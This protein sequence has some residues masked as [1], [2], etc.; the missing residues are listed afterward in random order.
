M[1]RVTRGRVIKAAGAPAIPADPAPPSRAVQRIAREELDAREAAARILADAK[2]AAAAL[3]DEA[4]AKASNVAETAAREAADA[5]QAK[6]AAQYLALR[7]REERSAAAQLDRSVEL[8]RVLAERLVGESL[9]VDEQTVAK[10]ARQ[11]LAEA[12][13]ARTVRI[14]AHP[15]DLAALERHLAL[16]N[17]G[18]VASIVSDATLQRG[19]L[20]LHTDSRNHRCAA[21]T[22][23]RTTRRRAPRRPPNLRSR[24]P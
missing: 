18:Q 21:Q 12:R 8:A 3:V 10:L 1:A 7:A 20:R 19:C 23:A 6:L 16:L 9:R 14:E 5:E 22:S 13:G 11:A 15:D 24:R 17:V 4:R 2:R